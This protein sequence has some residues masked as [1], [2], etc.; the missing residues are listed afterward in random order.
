MKQRHQV[1]SF[2]NNFLDDRAAAGAVMI[3]IIIATP[4]LALNVLEHPPGLR[5]TDL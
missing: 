5:S 4:Q 2:W 1:K 3:V